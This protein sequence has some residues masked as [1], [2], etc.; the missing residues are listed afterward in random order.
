M[1]NKYTDKWLNLYNDQM[2]I[3][4]EKVKKIKT[5]RNPYRN[6][7]RPDVTAKELIKE[8][9]S[10]E[11]IGETKN[12]SLAGRVM[13]VRAFGKAAFVKLDDGSDNF[14][15]YI[16]QDILPAEDF[17]EY[18][19]VDHAD[20]IFV[21]GQVFKTQKGELSLKAT[22]FKILTKALR[23]L[24]EKY[25][26]LTDPEICYRQRYLDMIMNSETRKKL[27]IRSE[28]VHYIREC[29]YKSGYL[30]VE[31]PM[32]HSIAGGATARP[33]HTH[34]NALDMELF[35]RI[36]PELHLKRLIVGG[37]TKVFEMNRCFRNEGLSVKHNPEFTSVEYYEAYATCAD[38]M[39][40][41]EEIICH[42]VQKVLN[43]EIIYYGEKE[44]SFKR[45]FKKIT[46]RDS[47]VQ[48]GDLVLSDLQT[49]ESLSKALAKRGVDELKIGKTQSLGSLINIAFEELV[50]AKLIQP[51]FISEYPVE[52]SPLAR[53]NDDNPQFVDR[54]ELFING[55]EISNAFSE[56]NDPIE[57]LERF[58][59]QALK[60]EQGDLEACDV[61][62]DYVRA[63]EYGMPPTA[64]AA[65]GIDRFCMLLTS[66]ETIRDVICFPL[67]KKEVF[68]EEEQK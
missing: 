3:R 63:L 48:I 30:E 24:P 18:E 17:K 65:I 1:S 54:F 39:H 56:L 68:F 57:Q 43:K 4:L 32:L 61:D 11:N 12:Y 50:E 42:T 59:D 51:T 52:I 9:E 6:G 14:Q 66:S 49:V 13:I 10:Q 26:G 35:L 45:P 33:F 25:H 5:E 46:M 40:F 38:Q 27:Q 55:W 7:Y 47:L 28:I 37:Y 19:M 58:A 41:T 29:F 34:H 53:R 44:I 36:A 23:P 60:K 20:I 21:Q 16:R 31:T 22:Q 8:Y 64:G 62:Y 67:L 2:Q 15:I